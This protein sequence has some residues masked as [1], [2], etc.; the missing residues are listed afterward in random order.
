MGKNK[1][2]IHEFDPVIYPYKVWVVIGKT[3]DAIEDSFNEYTDEPIYFINRDTDKAEAFTMPVVHKE[4]P[5]YGVLLFFRSRKSMTYGL[6]A[7]ET[8]HAAKYLFE[9]IGADIT[10]HEPFEYVVG[11]IAGCCEKVKKNKIKNL[12]K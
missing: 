9:H 12:G 3:P 5:H 8:S 11:W 2:E 7:H 10:E 1:I 6:V 4:N